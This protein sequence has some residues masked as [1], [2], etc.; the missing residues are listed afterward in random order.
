MFF[1]L[2]FA[3]SVPV[4]IVALFMLFMMTLIWMFPVAYIIMVCTIMTA[5]FESFNKYLEE[6][7]TQNLVSKTCQ[8]Q[9]LR[10]LHLNLSKMVS[11]LDKDFGIYFAFIFVFIIGFVCVLVYAGLKTSMDNLALLA[12]IFVASSA[13]SI[14]GIVSVYAAFVHEAVSQKKYIA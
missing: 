2:P 5:S 1:A 3:E 9:R 12:I 11:Y 13:L 10:Q 14:L 8:F 6:N 4:I 7:L